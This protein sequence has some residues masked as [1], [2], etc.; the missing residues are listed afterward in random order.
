MRAVRRF[1]AGG[2]TCVSSLIDQRHTIFK[3]HWTFRSRRRKSR[4]FTRTSTKLGPQNGA[5]EQNPVSTH[6]VRAASQNR[7]ELAKSLLRNSKSVLCL[8]LGRYSC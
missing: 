2:E 1:C 5:I 8:S 6:T 4:F 7:K 3:Q